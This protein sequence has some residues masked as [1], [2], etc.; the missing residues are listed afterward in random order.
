M[1]HAPP[2]LDADDDSLLSVLQKID[3]TEAGLERVCMLAQTS[4][5]CARAV[6]ALLADGQFRRTVAIHREF[7]RELAVLLDAPWTVLCRVVFLQAVDADGT[8]N[9]GR[10]LRH[11]QLCHEDVD[12]QYG[13]CRLLWTSFLPQA[14]KTGTVHY[15]ACE[16]VGREGVFGVLL[17]MLRTHPHEVKLLVTVCWA[18][19]FLI[20]CLESNRARFLQTDGLER[21]L[22]LE[23]ESCRPG[24]LSA[25]IA[26]D[27]SRRGM[28]PDAIH[29]YINRHSLLHSIRH[30]CNTVTSRTRT[31]DDT[32]V[33]FVNEAE[34]V[35]AARRGASLAL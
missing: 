24:V 9:A 22:A 29:V 4:R 30:V 35:A 18:L 33:F 10:I 3:V 11:A 12:L 26:V 31:R 16:T 14:C 15:E 32:V 1:S 6:R 25:A 23:H 17:C 28:Y 13:V 21:L 20:Q 8:T 2:A 7:K 5:G 19:S 34:R 27:N